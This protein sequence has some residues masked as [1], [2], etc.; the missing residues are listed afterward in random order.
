MVESVD[1]RAFLSRLGS[2]R[3][4]FARGGGR[5]PRFSQAPSCN[6]RSL[7]RSNSSTV[8]ELCLSSLRCASSAPVSY[9]SNGGSVL[10]SPHNLP[11]LRS[12]VSRSRLPR[13]LPHPI[14]TT[15]RRIIW[16][17][18]GALLVATTVRYDL[19]DMSLAVSINAL[20][21]T[22]IIFNTRLHLVAAQ[23]RYSFEFPGLAGL[24]SSIP[25]MGV[26]GIQP[27]VTWH[28]SQGRNYG[29]S[30]RTCLVLLLRCVSGSTQWFS[31]V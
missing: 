22:P 28:S 1:R 24:Y 3:C 21:W 13:L 9:P 26:D 6:A 2:G 25:T 31:S 19:P 12:S 29:G 5:R 7:L 17:I 20:S 11:L 8:S 10:A 14:F 4:H 15:T 23:P 30:D 18:A 27:G 16:S